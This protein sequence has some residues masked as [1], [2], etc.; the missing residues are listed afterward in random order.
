MAIVFAIL[1]LRHYLLGRRFFM[2]TDQSSLRFLLEQ[3]EVGTDYQKWVTKI[4]GFDFEITYNPRASNRVADALSRRVQPTILLGALCS[5]HVV[6]WSELDRAVEQDEMLSSIKQRLRSRQEVL[7]GFTLEREQLFYKGRFVVP[8]KHFFIKSILQHYHD[9]P[10]GGHYSGEQ[11]N[12][13]RS[14]MN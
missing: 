6:D 5:T 11:K 8:K 9:S 10:I 12:E 2:R 7:K 13:M 4:M 14:W 3:R 1:K